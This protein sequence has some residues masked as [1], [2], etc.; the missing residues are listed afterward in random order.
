[1]HCN[2]FDFLR[3]MAATTVLVVH[4]HALSGLAAPGIAGF[5]HWATIAVFVF[6]SISGYLVS[7]S[8]FCDPNVWRFCVRR[9]LRIW[10]A[11]TVTVTIG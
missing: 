7:Q 8:F 2:N 9:F 6:F 5:V 3:I 10:P 11:F 4:H 1:M